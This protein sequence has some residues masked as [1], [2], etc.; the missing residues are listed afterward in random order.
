MVI[1]TFVLFSGFE[2]IITYSVGGKSSLGTPEMMPVV[3]LKERP[4]GRLPMIVIESILL[5]MVGIMGPTSTS[6]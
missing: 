1:V 2:A 6:L 4:S 3:E 5:P